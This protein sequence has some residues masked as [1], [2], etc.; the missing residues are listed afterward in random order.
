MERIPKMK[1]F[2]E[3]RMKELLDKRLDAIEKALL[4]NQMNI[5]DKIEEVISVQSNFVHSH[6][7]YDK[8]TV[9]YLRSSYITGSHIFLFTCQKGIL[10]LEDSLPEKELALSGLFA[11]VEQDI[12]RLGTEMNQKFIRVSEGEKETIRRW[13]MELLY[14]HLGEVLE[15]IIQKR[16]YLTEVPLLY[17]GYMEEQRQIG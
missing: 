6:Q 15:V 9:S 8:L 3:I 1:A 12:D 16:R 7:E 13:Y 5:W 10:F 2:L 11:E 14:V 17:G 4:K